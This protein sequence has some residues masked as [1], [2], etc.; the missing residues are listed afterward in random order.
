MR[1]R[2]E[3]SY[4]TDGGFSS[5]PG[6]EGVNYDSDAWAAVGGSVSATMVDGVVV[7]AFR[8][9]NLFS[10][11]DW[12][13]NIS[14]AF[15]MKTGQY[16]LAV[17]LAEAVDLATNSNVIITGHS[18]GGGLASAAS[19]ATGA[20]AVTFNSAGLSGRYAT[21]NAAN[22]TAINIRGDILSSLQDITPL[23]SASGN[24][25][26]RPSNDWHKGPF[27]RHRVSQF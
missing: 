19:H 16:E 8:G 4:S 20:Q 27:G 15:G 12:R 24:R 21:G 25:I 14:Q 1:D 10:P 26:N 9:T 5:I 18:L 13:T 22:I 2:A 6:L 7:V 3:A 23:R 11:K 17:E